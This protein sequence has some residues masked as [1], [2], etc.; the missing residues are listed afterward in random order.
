[1]VL[2]TKFIY[3]PNNE[4]ILA[5]L[6]A[7]CLQFVYILGKD[8]DC[9]VC[10]IKSKHTRVQLYPAVYPHRGGRCCKV[11]L[12]QMQNRNL[13]LGIPCLLCTWRKKVCQDSGSGKRSGITQ[14]AFHS[15][16]RKRQ[17]APW[18]HLLFIKLHYDS[19]IR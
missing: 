12:Q 5:Q 13:T 18:R 2:K 15:L 10:L 8:A 16:F 3:K 1:M 17:Y 4:E 7:L 6:V 9:T 14:G 19:C 11:W